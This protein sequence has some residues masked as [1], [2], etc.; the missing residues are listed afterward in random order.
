MN[1]GNNRKSHEHRQDL[2]GEY[3][4]GDLGQNILLIIFFIGMVVDVFLVKVSSWQDVVPW[5]IRVVIFIPLFVFGWYVAQQAHKKV[6]QEERTNLMVIT[7]GVYAWL[8]H[9]MYFGSLMIYLSF[10]LLS[11]SV[12]A[13][14]IFGVAVLFYH[15]L[16]RYEE[17]LLIAKL[18][19]EYKEYM[20]KVRI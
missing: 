7:T 1:E 10:I 11:F 19:D 6:F 18:G 5:Y 2:A 16:C 20:K 15:Y 8:R 3:R 13:L 4:W 14:T 12:I 17:K 9:P